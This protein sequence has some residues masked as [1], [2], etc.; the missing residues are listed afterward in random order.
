MW[1]FH[2]TVVEN[3]V[4]PVNVAFML[5]LLFA[6]LVLWNLVKSSKNYKLFQAVLNK[7]FLFRLTKCFNIFQY[8]C[9]DTLFTFLL[10]I[11]TTET[12]TEGIKSSD[13]E[14]FIIFKL[15]LA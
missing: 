15:K 3:K 10:N 13:D 9:Q 11:N 6:I 4:L 1:Y 2:T 8:F 12:C 7:I 5:S 14:K